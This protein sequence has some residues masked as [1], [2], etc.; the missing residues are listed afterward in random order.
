LLVLDRQGQ[1]VMIEVREM[2]EED[3]REIAKFL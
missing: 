2:L 3:V 1:L